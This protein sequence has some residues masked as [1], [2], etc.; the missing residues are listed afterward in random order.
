MQENARRKAC[1]VPGKGMGR[2]GKGG[3]L[4]VG[5]GHAMGTAV[6]TVCPRCVSSL[7]QLGRVRGSRSRS[8]STSSV[9]DEVRWLSMDHRPGVSGAGCWLVVQGADEETLA[10]KELCCLPTTDDV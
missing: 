3:W 7:S 1:G 6:S 8:G 4:A 9:H 5:W 10:H 2:G